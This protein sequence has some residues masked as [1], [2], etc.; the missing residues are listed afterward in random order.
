MVTAQVRIILALKTNI[1]RT[2]PLPREYLTKKEAQRQN[3][4]IKKLTNKQKVEV[5]FVF[6]IP[7]DC[8]C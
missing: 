8:S 3:L 6:F 2:N 5:S 4:N 1:R 7:S